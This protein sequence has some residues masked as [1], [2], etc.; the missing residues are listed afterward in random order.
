MSSLPSLADDLPTSANTG[1][2][3]TAAVTSPSKEDHG[4]SLCYLDLTQHWR[5]IPVFMYVRVLDEIL[6]LPIQMPP[7]NINPAI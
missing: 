1:D 7:K 5:L 4:M 3:S 6:K 2:E